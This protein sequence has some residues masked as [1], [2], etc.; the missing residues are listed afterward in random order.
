[1]CYLIAKRI[2]DIGCV[3]LQT[4]HGQHLADF[5]EKLEKAVGYDKVQ[6]VIISRPSAYGEYEPYRFVYNEQD[7]EQAVMAMKGASNAL[8]RLN[9]R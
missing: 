6:L 5:E 2:D 7:F 9:S 1:M 4:T 3:A 8:Q